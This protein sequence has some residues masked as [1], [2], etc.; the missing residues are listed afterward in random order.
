MDKILSLLLKNEQLTLT[1]VITLGVLIVLLAL[2]LVI[3]VI[4]GRELSLGPLKISGKTAQK[5]IGKNHPKKNNSK[6]KKNPDSIT[7]I[8]QGG[9]A[10]QVLSELIPLSRNDIIKTIKKEAK[11]YPKKR[12]TGNTR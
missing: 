1:L 5:I 4:Q 12:G 11:P 10:M 3:V 2:M 9:L 7:L 6:E 8:V